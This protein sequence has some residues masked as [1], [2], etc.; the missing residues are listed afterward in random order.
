M[1]GSTQDQNS[2]AGLTG[3]EPR[4]TQGIRPR[5]LQGM[6]TRLKKLEDFPAISDSSLDR[7]NL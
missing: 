4:E 2:V 7:V 6:L 5:S 1:Q 3:L